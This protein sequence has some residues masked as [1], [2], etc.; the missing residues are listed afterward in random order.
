MKPLGLVKQMIEAVGLEIAYAY[1]DLVFVS[2]NPFL[3]QFSEAPGEVLV[4]FNA[5]CPEEDAGRIFE[6][7]QRA[8]ADVGLAVTRAGRY[9]LTQGDEENMSLTFL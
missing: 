8:G 9:E 2:H 1:D 3:V 5:E 6:A 4:H 7:L